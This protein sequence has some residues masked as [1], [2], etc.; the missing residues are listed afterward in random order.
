MNGERQERALAEHNN[1]IG[2]LGSI[3]RRCSAAK[4]SH[5]FFRALGGEE[6]PFQTPCLSGTTYQPETSIN[7]L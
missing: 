1:L 5:R 3:V 6:T 4:H 7:N 2:A